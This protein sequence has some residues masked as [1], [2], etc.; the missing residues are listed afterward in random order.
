MQATTPRASC[1][2]HRTGRSP[3]ALSADL[4]SVHREANAADWPTSA[5]GSWAAVLERYDPYNTLATTLRGWSRR[6]V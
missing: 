3:S 2:P 6:V 4:L 5:Y 1:P